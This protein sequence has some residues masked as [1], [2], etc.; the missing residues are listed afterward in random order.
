M[1]D[2]SAAIFIIMGVS[3]SGK[4]TLGHALSAALNLCFLD[5]DDFHPPENIAKM[6]AEIPLNDQDREVWLHNLNQ[7]AKSYQTSGA[8]IACSALKERY[9]K[10]LSNE[11]QDC[12]SWIVLYE[13][14]DFINSRI[15]DR[16][17]HFMPPTLLKSQFEILEL[18]DYGLHLSARLSTA[19]MLTQILNSESE[20]PYNN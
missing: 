11:L 4:T 13:S 17:D 1:T 8:V 5:G 18:P 6:S 10:I 14:L 15:R 3:A 16:K 19:E 2:K 20:K 12:I 9:R 7:A